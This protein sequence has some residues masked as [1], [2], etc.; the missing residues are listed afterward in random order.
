[1]INQSN[2]LGAD[3][4]RYRASL[5]A[6]V[7]FLIRNFLLFSLLFVHPIF[8]LDL[9]RLIVALAVVTA[10]VTAINSFYSSYHVQKQ[11]VIE[12]SLEQSRVYAT[13]LAV[14]TNL[15]LQGIERQLASSSWMLADHFQQQ[16][17]LEE[18]TERLA[19]QVGCFNAVIV[20]DAQG[21]IRAM[22]PLN[23]SMKSSLLS[24]PAVQQMLGNRRPFISEPYTI[25]SNDVVIILSA[26]IIDAN[27][28]YLGYIAG[29][30]SLRQPN[31]LSQLLGEHYYHDGS[32]VLVID[33]NRH[34][35]YDKDPQEIGQQMATSAVTEAVKFSDN[36]S[37]VVDEQQVNA[38]VSG[39]SV[40]PSSGWE[41]IVQRP[42]AL[43]LQP[44]DS[45]LFK[46][47]QGVMPVALM[48]LL[49]VWFCSRW[50]ASPLLML[51]QSANKMDETDISRKIDKLPSW[52]FEV[53]QLKGAMLMGINLMQRKIG[54]LKFEVQTDPMTG[55]FNRRGLATTLDSLQQIRQ[56]FAVV[57]LDIDHFK[58]INDTYGHAAGD[59]VIKRL[60]LLIR[61]CSRSS[62]ILCRNGGEEFL[63]LLPGAPLHVA[64]Q[65]AQRLRKKVEEMCIPNVA[66][67]TISL[68]VSHWSNEHQ[69]PVETI[70]KL[71]DDALY[72]AK[73]HGR[74]RVEILGM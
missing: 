29:S 63:M 2:V 67:V 55:L 1:M 19:Y 53:K 37:Q 36:G 34:I 64:A 4:D 16:A 8:R 6:S 42:M 50:I 18:E 15:V 32:S 58:H 10:L 25:D 35:L 66:G 45:M 56:S 44:L 57:A 11:L 73:Q 9:R 68:G 17:V 65:I 48:T 52:Y 22:A 62:D 14:S 54:R 46:V 71:A 51:A 61:S 23:K 7:Y 3:G 41:V 43:S 27:G 60:A 59:E 24:L 28:R 49:F 30:I 21:N 26:P 12:N 40:V 70:L 5:M 39:Y 33:Q 69:E 31:A 72:K 74:N 20:S 47:L 13:K 38:K